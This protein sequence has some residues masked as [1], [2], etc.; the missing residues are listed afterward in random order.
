MNWKLIRNW[1]GI[2]AVSMLLILWI[3][4]PIAW[5]VGIGLGITAAAFFL[6]GKKLSDFNATGTTPAGAPAPVTPPPSRNKN[7]SNLMAYLAWPLL[8][9]L[10]IPVIDMYV[11]KG[12][13]PIGV[14]LVMAAAITLALFFLNRR[15]GVAGRAKSAAQTGS[16]SLVSAF[17][18]MLSSG[19][20]ITIFVLSL[21]AIGLVYLVF[22]IYWATLVMLI[23]VG[24]ASLLGH[25]LISDEWLKSRDLLIFSHFFGE[26]TYGEPDASSHR[27]NW[28]H[29]PTG[30][31]WKYFVCLSVALI[32]IGYLIPASFPLFGFS[33]DTMIGDL[34]VGRI[35]FYV[36]LLYLI[37]S[38]LPFGSL[39]E[40]AIDKEE[41]GEGTGNDI[42]GIGWRPFVRI[43][44]R[45]LVFFFG[46]AV[47]EVSGSLWIPLPMGISWVHLY[48]KNHI[49]RERLKKGQRLNATREF[50]G[51]PISN[52][53]KATDP[54]SRAMTADVITA[55]SYVIPRGYLAIFEKR[56]SS[57]RQAN[58][59]I[60]DT[61]SAE[62]EVVLSPL[63]YREVSEHMKAVGNR[64]HN[65]CQLRVREPYLNTLTG[66]K[67][68]KDAEIARR[69]Y[70]DID[71]YGIDMIYVELKS[72]DPDSR[73]TTADN[74]DAASIAQLS[75]TKRVAEGIR[76]T[77][78]AEA[79]GP[80]EALI[81]AV[82]KNAQT[83]GIVD[84]DGRVK[85]GQEDS[86]RK[87]F[88]TYIATGAMKDMQIQNINVGDSI[89]GLL[90]NFIKQK[91]A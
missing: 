71:T 87:L 57:I 30:L 60:E 90:K 8:G 69:G 78:K 6:T 68:E 32:I 47:C 70:T 42:G 45:G 11:L 34:S 10:L 54:K 41:E 29:L 22:P 27:R 79:I 31:N 64:L 53:L 91:A 43:N 39:K 4:T 66:T 14:P 58:K 72:V 26:G 62:N 83:L 38:G 76:V 15:F 1:A 16:N 86:L 20:S 13:S 25:A 35:Y 46:F 5:A 56:C 3:G 74:E 40:L 67:K 73:I 84:E 85:P 50:D 49:Q 77:K 65:V 24:L 55:R 51:K 7:Q 21:I 28:K 18:A 89:Y 52:A 33:T 75:K 81:E 17:N 63:S 88:D 36:V 82:T 80:Y 23:I 59:L 9:L 12:K 44:E 19:I 2:F 37:A 61:V 48:P